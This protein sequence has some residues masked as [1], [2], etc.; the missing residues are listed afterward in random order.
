[1]AIIL[2]LA[3]IPI[4]MGAGAALDFGRAYLVKA[5]LSYALDTAGLAIGAS[6]PNSNFQQILNNFFTA[7][8]SAAEIGVPATPSFTTNDGTIKLVAQAKL[9]TTFLNLFGN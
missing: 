2:A 1:M 8:Y 9:K 6:N 4:L 5:R 3:F 7:N